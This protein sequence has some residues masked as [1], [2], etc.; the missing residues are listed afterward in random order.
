MRKNLV[1]PIICN[2]KNCNKKHKKLRNNEIK[3][4]IAIFVIFIIFFIL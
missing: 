1:H 4:K 2:C 3:I